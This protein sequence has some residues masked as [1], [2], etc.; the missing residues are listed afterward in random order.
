MRSNILNINNATNGP[1]SGGGISQ[2][3]SF[4]PS[5]NM[6]SQMPERLIYN[7]TVEYFIP[8]IARL[9]FVSGYSLKAAAAKN[10]DGSDRTRDI[11]NECLLT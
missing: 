6:P 7:L 1:P 11:D 4:L 9:T 8:R 3:I 5:L 2:K 10:S